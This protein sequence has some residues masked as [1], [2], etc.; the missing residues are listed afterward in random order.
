MSSLIHWRQHHFLAR[1]NWYWNITANKKRHDELVKSIHE[2]TENIILSRRKEKS[3]N[4]NQSTE[5]KNSVEEI[6]IRKRRALLDLLLEST[7][8]GKPL[9]NTDIQEESDNFMFAGHDT[10]TSAITFL[11]Y[12]LAKHP[13]V[14]EKVY[15]EVVSILGADSSKPLTVT[16]LN[17]F[18]YLDLVIKESLRMYS[19]VPIIG[20]Y[21]REDVEISKT[22]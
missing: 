20:R 7:I 9:T 13:D 17:S 5:R 22:T 15:S 3:L 14:Q 4:M 2:H 18:Q 16:D 10:T 6:G 11:L 19:P 1:D 21:L 8:D 12:N